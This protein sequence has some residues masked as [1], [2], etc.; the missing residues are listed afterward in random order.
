MAKQCIAFNTPIIHRMKNIHPVTLTNK[1]INI[2]LSSYLSL[3]RWQPH[4]LFCALIQLKMTCKLSSKPLFVTV[5]FVC[6]FAWQRDF[7]ESV[8]IALCCL[9]RKDVLFNILCVL[10]FFQNVSSQLRLR[11]FFHGLIVRWSV[12][13]WCLFEERECQKK[14]Q[15]MINLC[16]V[17]VVLAKS[18]PVHHAPFSVDTVPPPTTKTL[19]R[20]ITIRRDTC[21]SMS[22]LQKGLPEATAHF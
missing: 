15:K 14:P 17:P 8:H 20:K 16:H 21:S 7:L 9:I 10:V 1:I 6:L 3:I 19:K 12:L 18:R 4:V 11:L 2:T 5:V 13:P 22:I